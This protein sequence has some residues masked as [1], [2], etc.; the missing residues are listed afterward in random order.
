MDSE[1][2][3]DDMITRG[4]IL[5]AGTVDTDLINLTQ[6][7][8]QSGHH[9]LSANDHD[10]AIEMLGA[11]NFDLLVNQ[12]HRDG[13]PDLDVVRARE[14]LNR[15]IPTIIL[16]DSPT[17]ESATEAIQLAVTA[18]LIKPC[19]TGELF[20]TIE[21]CI[22]KTRSR[23]A[24]FDILERMDSWS[25]EMGSVEKYLRSSHE[26][27]PD[28]VDIKTFV[29]L[30]MGRIL[31][32]LMDLKALLDVAAEKDSGREACHLLACPRL[33]ACHALIGETIGTLEKT[34]NYFKSRDL[35]E[36]R[37]R[38]EEFLRSQVN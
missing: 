38:L 17:L 37:V 6:R 29:P 24:C 26:E 4:K 9:C 35:H 16:T 19:D 32:S 7:L 20:R 8:E 14:P 1:Q 22:G 28:S 11:S 3:R 30:T 10:T 33:H 31:G 23:R 15:G 21:E 34:K 12:L 36:L 5:L 25:R 13:A 2:A 18:Y 27:A